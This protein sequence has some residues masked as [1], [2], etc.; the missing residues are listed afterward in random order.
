MRLYNIYPQQARWEKGA[1]G[2]EENPVQIHVLSRDFLPS[3][4]NRV[5]EDTQSMF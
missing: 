3:S 4:K 2:Q 1:V 5:V